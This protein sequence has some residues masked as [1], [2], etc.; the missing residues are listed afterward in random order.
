MIMRKNDGT[1]INKNTQCL[2]DTDHTCCN[3]DIV[4]D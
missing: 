4:N 2:L 3:G 1:K